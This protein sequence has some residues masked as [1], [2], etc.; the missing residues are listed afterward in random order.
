MMKNSKFLLSL[1]LVVLV[2]FTF[3]PI[4]ADESLT[5]ILTNINPISIAVNSETNTI[6]AL[7][8]DGIVFIIQRGACQEEYQINL[9]EVTTASIAVN[10]NNN[11]IY[12]IDILN[13]KVF[14]IDDNTN[15]VIDI[16]TVPH[17]L[18]LHIWYDSFTNI[19]FVSY[20]T[21]SAGVH[22]F[23]GDTHENL[24]VNYP[25]NFL[26][27][28]ILNPVTN[29]IYDVSAVYTIEVFDGD[30]N[31]LIDTIP[32]PGDPREISVNTN[33]N[34]VYV[35]YHNPE[36]PISVIDG[37]GNSGKYPEHNPL[38][39]T[40]GNLRLTTENYGVASIEKL[41]ENPTSSLPFET[42]VGSFY[43][44]TSCD[45]LGNRVIT[46]S[47]TDEE[48][49]GLD[50]S[51][52]VISRY[53]EGVWSDL[54]TLIDLEEN[55]AR[56]VTP[57]FST[58]VLGISSSSDEPETKKSGGGCNDC[59][60]P[61]FGKDKNDKMIVS[62]GFTY[63]GI[64][65]DVTDYHTE[66]PL[67]TVITNAT[68]AVTLKIY[69][70]QGVN[71][72]KMVQFGMGMPE[73]GSPL[74]DAQSLVE[75]FLSGIE[76]EEIN[77]IDPNNLVDITGATTNVVNC[78]DDSNTP[79]LELTLQ[80]VYRDQPKYNIMAINAIDNSRNSQTNYLN[81]GILVTGESLNEPLLL[82]TNVANSNAF[83][84]QRAGS[85]LLTLLDYKT[86]MW[87]DEY[88][89]MWSTDQW[90]GSYMVEYPPVPQ[91]TPDAYSKWSGY[92]DRLHS[93]FAAYVIQQQQR[94]QE[95]MDKQYYKSPQTT[96]IN[97][98]IISTEYQSETSY[99]LDEL[100]TECTLLKNEY[101]AQ[102]WLALEYPYIAKDKND[103]M[104]NDYL[105]DS[106]PLIS[107]S[108]EIITCD[109]KIQALIN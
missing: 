60:P 49:E 48:I 93:E 22:S 63:N 19:I 33:T 87:Q 86:D 100:Y 50:E 41:H 57:G 66:F 29:V 16:F 91:N 54:H 15:E 43:E 1:L 56:A 81:D 99:V 39:M 71:N 59:T 65:T 109:A 90:G 4:F 58:F 28:T 98:I 31:E 9:G 20:L 107:L 2:V 10:P 32:V 46:I 75:V 83:Y 25:N 69:E 47:Y 34:E 67:I 3:D 94:A 76:I 106:V 85:V 64:S 5:P 108:A 77:I 17:K 79:C 84:P 78:M 82:T 37:I 18:P 7:T 26:Y 45:D 23:N 51:S 36:Y 97:D 104:F 44:L 101:S 30:T 11:E 27:N 73:I 8:Q 105:L 72:I 14:V 62:D 13:A 95:T 38:D 102:V 103:P 74:Y 68:N 40:V 24:N 92:N 21:T 80:Y 55:T 6:Y 52:L 12:V 35:T 88:G 70:N 53:T 89:Y 42:F 61:T 96:A